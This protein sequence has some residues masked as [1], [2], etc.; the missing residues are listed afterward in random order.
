MSWHKAVGLGGGRGSKVEELRVPTGWCRVWVGH[1]E[2]DEQV[3]RQGVGVDMHGCL[4]VVEVFWVVNR[5]MASKYWEGS[6]T[7]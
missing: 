1:G 7:A 4:G 5:T 2:G 6:K 3:V